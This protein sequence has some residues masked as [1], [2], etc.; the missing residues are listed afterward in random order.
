VED[1]LPPRREGAAPQRRRQWRRW[2]EALPE[3]LRPWLSLAPLTSLILPGSGQLLRGQ[4]N[5][6]ITIFSL[7]LISMISGYVFIATP[8]TWI[9]WSFILVIHMF[10][11]QQ[12][13]FGGKRG[14]WGERLLLLVVLFALYSGIW[15]ATGFEQ[16]Q[17]NEPYAPY[18]LLPQPLICAGDRLLVS[19]NITPTA[20]DIILYSAAGNYYR[21]NDYNY[22]IMGGPR[23]GRIIIPAG[24][25]V[26]NINIDMFADQT[27]TPLDLTAELLASAVSL[28]PVND[29]EAV[30]LFQTPER[31]EEGIKALLTVEKIPQEAIGGTI[32]R[33]GWPWDRRRNL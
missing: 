12:I 19:S 1:F 22:F 2:H 17:V 5:Q 4:V 26:E 27:A 11:C 21:E 3:R 15:H 23:V 9:C 7:W 20:G 25:E 14:S 24:T 13:L 28:A 16:F 29:D 30:I 6:G 18:L 31:R 10:A 33:I 32:T 8:Y